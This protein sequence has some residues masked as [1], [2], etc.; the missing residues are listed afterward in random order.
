MAATIPCP[1]CGHKETVADAHPSL[2]LTDVAIFQCAECGNR[3]IHGKTLPR[4]VVEPFVDERG[5]QWLRRRFQDPTTKR[6]LFVLDVDPQ[7]A[8]ADAINILS[9][10]GPR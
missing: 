2:K 5:F 8:A 6:D 10:V 3:T 9:I 4:L 1:I 7:C